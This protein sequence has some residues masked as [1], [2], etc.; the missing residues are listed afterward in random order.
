M[1]YKK[2]E[3]VPCPGFS[4][5]RLGVQPQKTILGICPCYTQKVK[6]WMEDRS[7]RF[8]IHCERAMRLHGGM[9]KEKGQFH[10]I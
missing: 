1:T 10:D 3:T 4:Q 2:G 6:I 7:C 9:V 8:F 5:N